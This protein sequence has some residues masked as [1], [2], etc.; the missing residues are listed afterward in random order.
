MTPMHAY[1]TMSEE[2]RKALKEIQSELASV[3]KTPVSLADAISSVTPGLPDPTF[4][5]AA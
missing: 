5:R 2:D 3:F 4:L 1:K